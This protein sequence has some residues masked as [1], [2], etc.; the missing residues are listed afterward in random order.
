MLPARHDFALPTSMFALNPTDFTGSQQ[1]MD[2]MRA[3]LD[4]TVDLR[5]LSQARELGEGKAAAV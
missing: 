2:A 3:V 4:S 5:S 1:D